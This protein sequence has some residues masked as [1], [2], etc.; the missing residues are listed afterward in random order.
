MKILTIDIETAPLTGYA[1]GEWDT[2]IIKVI[3]PIRMLCFAAKWDDDKKVMFFS[4]NG[5]GGRL[6]M[7][8]ALWSLLDDADVVVH[9]NGQQF[10]M[11]HINREFW[12]NDFNPYKPVKQVDLLLAARKNFKFSSNKLD[13]L[14]EARGIGNKIKH[15]G[16]ALWEKVMAG[17]AAAWKR[18]KKYN[19]QDVLLTEQL[20]RDMFA[21]IP[22]LPSR[23]LYDGDPDGCPSC[24]ARNLMKRGFAYTAQSKFQQ[25]QC[26]S[27]MR[28]FRSTKR[29]DGTSLVN[30]VR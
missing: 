25:F 6:G 5:E 27:C 17:D 20:Y 1:W 22:G 12:L 23:H 24:G 7:L 9:F 18:M 26:M 30:V 29:I 28:Y 8:T 15:E 3:S 19:M 13:R 10:D 4:E 14:V 11:K 21:W 16:F 2:N